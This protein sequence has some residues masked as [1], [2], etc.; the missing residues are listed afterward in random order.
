MA[1]D[2]PGRLRSLG[3]LPI[4]LF[5]KDN[6]STQIQATMVNFKRALAESKGVGRFMLQIG[7]ETKLRHVIVKGI[8]KGKET[9]EI[10]RLTLMEIRETDRITLHVPVV[11]VGRPKLVASGQAIL[12]Q[13]VHHVKLKGRAGVLPDTVKVD[14]SKLGMNGVIAAKD[15]KI[16]PMASLDTPP[17]TI[18]L[19]VESTLGHRV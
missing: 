16:P 17:D 14:V 7:G 13:P 3:I 8:S 19:R 10:E 18:L 2:T 11:P 4:E 9:R 5:G 1:G 15:L 6:S 12:A